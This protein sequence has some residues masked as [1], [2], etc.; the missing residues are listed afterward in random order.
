M[1]DLIKMY[2]QY[3]KAARGEYDVAEYYS[4]V[5]VNLRRRKLAQS[6]KNS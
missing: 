4:Q 3:K 5:I 6:K 2:E 1:D